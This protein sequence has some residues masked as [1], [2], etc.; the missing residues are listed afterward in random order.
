MAARKASAL[1]GS[2]VGARYDRRATK[3]W[4]VS[5]GSADADTLFDVVE[6]RKRSRDLMRN[7]PI[8]LGAVN[9]V[10][11]NAIGTGLSL[12]CTPDLAGLGRGQGNRV[13]G[14]GRTRVSLVV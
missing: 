10:V 7:T 4:A 1:Y 2:Y 12:Q 5:H 9:T 3:E 11:Q 13:G 8:A 14:Q 6:L